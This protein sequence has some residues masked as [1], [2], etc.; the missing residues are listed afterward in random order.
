V[1]DPIPT[2]GSYN[3]SLATLDLRRYL[4]L[5]PDDRLSGRGYFAGWV[6]GGA[7]PIQRR[8]SLGGPS[9]LPGDAFRQVN[10]TPPGFNN[11][12]QASLCDRT[13]FFQVEYRHRLNLGWHYTL[14]KGSE[15]SAG[16]VI[17]I[18]AADLVFLSDI[19]SAWLT[20]SGPG[21]VPNNRLPSADFWSADIG[22]GIDFGFLGAYLAKS[23]T[24]DGPLRVS[25][26]LQ[27]RF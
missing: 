17:G 4:R 10:C 24:D 27:R 7:L 11:S 9:I 13:M 25:L 8:L 1:R 19:G 15:T 18:Q 23:V 6:G 26:R 12:S 2:D 16:R 21:R 3:Y 22:A 5:S 14:S 20:G